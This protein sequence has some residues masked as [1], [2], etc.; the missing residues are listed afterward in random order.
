MTGDPT[1]MTDDEE[2]TAILPA[3]MNASV[4]DILF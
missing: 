1:R 4:A 3:G 2:G